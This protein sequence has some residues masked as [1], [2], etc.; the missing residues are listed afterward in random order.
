MSNV[1]KNLIIFFIE[2]ADSV[3]NLKL[4]KNQL[5]SLGEFYIS[6]KYK[7]SNNLHSE[8]IEDETDIENNEM[9][10]VKFL[11]LGWWI[12][13]QMDKDIDTVE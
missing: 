13:T 3:E 5:K 9:D 7:E 4:N 6:Y 11:T 8:E 12:Y 10:I 1:D 2:L